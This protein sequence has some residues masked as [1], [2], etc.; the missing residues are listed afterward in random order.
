MKPVYEFCIFL[1]L[2]EA[3]QLLQVINSGD[4]VFLFCADGEV[5]SHCSSLNMRFMR[6]SLGIT[7]LATSYTSFLQSRELLLLRGPQSF[8]VTGKKI[9]RVSF[10]FP[11]FSAVIFSV[12]L[13]PSSLCSLPQGSVWPN[14]ASV[15][16][17][18][19]RRVRT[20]FTREFRWMACK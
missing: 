17:L 1:C 19:F 15:K 9:S 14:S 4:R 11:I 7:S 3:E 12:C 8:Q 16:N 6:Q 5:I 18:S 20:W 2:P 13:L 10:S